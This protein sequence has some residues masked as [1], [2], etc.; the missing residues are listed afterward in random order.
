MR[1][2]E[3]TGRSRSL[4]NRGCWD[5]FALHSPFWHGTGGRIRS[6]RRLLA[7]GDWVFGRRHTRGARLRLRRGEREVPR[8]TMFARDDFV[9]R[10]KLILLVTFAGG[11]DRVGDFV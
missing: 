9:D 11:P 6:R 1:H 3:R 4:V 7:R 8:L 2:R 10:R 5:R